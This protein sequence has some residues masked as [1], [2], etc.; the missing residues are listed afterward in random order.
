MRCFWGGG[1]SAAKKA[2]QANNN[3]P[4]RT[5]APETLL[6]E[7]VGDVLLA[8]WMV[9]GE[10]DVCAKAAL[11]KMGALGVLRW[12]GQELCNF[13]VER[14]AVKTT[15][16]PLFPNLHS[17]R[18]A[19]KRNVAAVLRALC[20]DDTADEI[21]PP[22]SSPC[23]GG[24]G[25]NGNGVVSVEWDDRFR[26]FL[27]APVDALTTVV[28]CA[29]LWDVCATASRGDLHATHRA[30]IRGALLHL[31]LS[32]PRL[33]AQLKSGKSMREA[34]IFAS[35]FTR[36]WLL[37]HALAA[38]PPHADEL[39]A[40]CAEGEEEEEEVGETATATAP[41]RASTLPKL[42]S[43][44]YALGLPR[45]SA[46]HVTE[47]PC[48]PVATP[49]AAA[50]ALFRFAAAPS[51]EAM[52]R[53]GASDD[54]LRLPDTD[55]RSP[56]ERVADGRRWLGLLLWSWR[57]WLTGTPDSPVDCDMEGATARC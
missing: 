8:E 17:K 4:L 37:V 7:L 32:L 41:P 52:L 50:A 2:L 20:E 21:L 35:C 18:E 48:P 54:F 16:C 57:S 55:A 30:A 47:S 24:G 33:T 9:E 3:H 39:A 51:D 22:I 34:R 40:C 43:L 1:G 12:R 14:M 46:L 15:T 31:K 25:T 53:G 38:S 13:L 10:T 36:L 27:K 6:D 5:V 56:A 42:L 23:R 19:A 29:S 28:A 44:R 45:G 11:H 26:T 49:G